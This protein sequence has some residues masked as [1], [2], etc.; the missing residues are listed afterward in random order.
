MTIRLAP[1]LKGVR[2]S[3][4]HSWPV[5][6]KLEERQIAKRAELPVNNVKRLIQDQPDYG[7]PI[8]YDR[9]PPPV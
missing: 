9:R 7:E 5:D 4:R 1:K 2:V 3:T 8:D 6:S